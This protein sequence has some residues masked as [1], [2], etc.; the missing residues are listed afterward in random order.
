[1]S[2]RMDTGMAQYTI[3]ISFAPVI[4]KFYKEHG[5]HTAT[6]V[7]VH[8]SGKTICTTNIYF[9]DDKLFIGYICCKN[10]GCFQR[11]SER[12]VHS[13]S[14]DIFPII[15]AN[16]NVLLDHLLS[17]KLPILPTYK[18]PT[19]LVIYN[20]IQ[21]HLIQHY[22]N[23][24]YMKCVVGKLLCIELPLFSYRLKE[25]QII[26]MVHKNIERHNRIEKRD[27]LIFQINLGRN[28]TLTYVKI[29]QRFSHVESFKK[30]RIQFS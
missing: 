8:W 4:L 13:S 23:W 6:E 14:S 2:R 15:S 9:V 11:L 21:I 22:S 12:V 10:S 25:N 30:M 29:I 7:F 24:I 26:V 17:N 19:Q 3:A 1:M 27:T 18:G 20:E 16:V 5:I 28:V